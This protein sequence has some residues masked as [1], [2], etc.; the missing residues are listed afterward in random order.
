M[1]RVY[2]EPDDVVTKV[3]L[4]RGLVKLP[5]RQ[6]EAMTLSLDGYTQAEIGELLGIN[7]RTAGRDLETARANLKDFLEINA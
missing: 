2:T 4:E 5:D 1:H 7:Q 3:E 6:R